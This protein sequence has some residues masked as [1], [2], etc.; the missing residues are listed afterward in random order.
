MCHHF[1]M[2]I[3]NKEINKNNFIFFI[4]KKV[5]YNNTLKNKN[6]FYNYND[7]LLNFLNNLIN[8]F[9]WIL[10]IK[11]RKGYRIISKYGKHDH[12]EQIISSDA[13][14]ADEWK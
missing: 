8:L 11:K 7:D 5:Q 6:I 3:N 14:T 10:L 13:N 1:I 12:T 9:I 2:I 4:N